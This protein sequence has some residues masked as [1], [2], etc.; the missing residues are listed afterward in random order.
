[1]LLI[2]LISVSVLLVGAAVFGYWAFGER[3][4]YKDRSDQKVAEAVTIAEKRTQAADAKQFAEEE[5]NPLKKYIGPAAFGSVT[6][7]YPK[8]WSAYVIEDESQPLNGY[9]HPDFVPSAVSP[10]K[11]FALRVE[12]VQQGYDQLLQQYS[13]QTQQGTVKIT[14]Y[15]L[16]KV[17]SIVGARV[18]GKIATNKDGVA[19]ILP[20]RNMTLKISSESTQFVPDLNNIILP[21]FVFTP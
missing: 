2:S 8:T 4:D 11:T 21:N 7:D 6:V 16:P 17:P 3:Q 18:E 12:L 9:F 14:P 1:M 19:I 10:D 20:L 13:G 15:S 5:K